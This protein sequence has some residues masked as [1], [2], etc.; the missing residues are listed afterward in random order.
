M[1]ERSSKHK[2]YGDMINEQVYI[3]DELQ[4]NDIQ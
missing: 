1:I 4:P 2:N 3:N